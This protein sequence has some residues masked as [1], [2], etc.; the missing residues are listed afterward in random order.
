MSFRPE[1]F[2]HLANRAVEKSAS[3]PKTPDE[4]RSH[5]HTIYTRW[6]D[7]VRPRR[8]PVLF[9][10]VIAKVFG[11]S[12]E[13]AVKRLMPIV[14]QINDF[15]PAIQ[16]LFDEQLRNKTAEFRQRIADALKNIEDTPENKEIGRAHV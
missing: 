13:R 2:A 6:W 7:K 15:E 1:R 3:L 4:P 14:K 5:P 12:N 16:A 8:T 11:T 10:K 9:N